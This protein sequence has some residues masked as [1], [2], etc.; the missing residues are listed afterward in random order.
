[1]RTRHNFFKLITTDEPD[2]Y[3]LGCRAV[4]P[5]ASS[6][7]GLI[8]MMIRFSRRVSDLCTILQPHPALTEGIQECARQI[9]GESIFKPE[10][11]Q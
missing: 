4:G 10:L 2:P 7:I 11:V 1:M 9:L 8:A 5:Q 6:I 3:I